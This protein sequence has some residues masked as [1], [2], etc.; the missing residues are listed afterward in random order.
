MV[1]NLS[2]NQATNSQR[3]C[4]ELRGW[5]TS[6]QP[7][8]V[9]WSTT[10]LVSTYL[11]LQV[12]LIK[13]ICP[14]TLCCDYFKCQARALTVCLLYCMF[15]SI[16]LAN[17]LINGHLNIFCTSQLL[18]PLLAIYTLHFLNTWRI[19]LHINY[20]SASYDLH[21]IF[22]KNSEFNA[23]PV[24]LKSIDL[25]GTGNGSAIRVQPEYQKYDWFQWY[26]NLNLPSDVK[27]YSFRKT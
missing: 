20:F 6:A 3:G 15:I 4:W 1:D 24:Y 25:R 13:Y 14:V 23:L 9:W 11:C 8:H 26:A 21:E 22:S 2:I 27:S 17:H 16:Y 7:K 10:E 19:Y 5:E 12:Y 18:L